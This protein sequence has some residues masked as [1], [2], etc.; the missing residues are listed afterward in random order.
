[1]QYVSLYVTT[2]ACIILLCHSSKLFVEICK[3]HKLKS[4]CTYIGLAPIVLQVLSYFYY[5]SKSTYKLG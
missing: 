4:L 5:L 2:A 3:I 1:M